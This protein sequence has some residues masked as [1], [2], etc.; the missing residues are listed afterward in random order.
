M[1]P[2]AKQLNLKW[3]ELPQVGNASVCYLVGAGLSAQSVFSAPTSNGFFARTFTKHCDGEDKEIELSDEA[4]GRELAGL[5]DRLETHYGPIKELDL[6]D[7][8]SDLYL[9]AFGIARAWGW[10]DDSR[11]PALYIP[12]LQADYRLLIR[13]VRERLPS[14]EWTEKRCPMVEKFAQLIRAQDSIVTLNYDTILERHLA[15]KEN[16]HLGYLES[17]IGPP[18]STYGGAAEPIFRHPG[19]SDG[20]GVFTKLHGSKDWYTC[21]NPACLNHTY[22][23]PNNPWYP[24]TTSMGKKEGAL[25]RCPACGSSRVPVIVPPTPSKSFEDFPKLGFLWSQS[26]HAFRMANL[27]VFIGVSLAR[28]DFH[29]SSFFRSL[30]GPSPLTG[31]RRNVEICVVNRDRETVTEVADRLT[32]AMSPHAANAFRSGWKSNP[33]YAFESIDQFVNAAGASDQRT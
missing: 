10:M 26:Y 29:L 1:G 14:V 21:S 11:D 6:E 3:N 24:S 7:V 31:Q 23:F 28:T 8:M 17:S 13:Y 30:T 4:A 32:L 18:G 15:D 12:D 5:L 16:H 33:I 25:L 19:P 20:R 2:E 27:W 9:R 22:I